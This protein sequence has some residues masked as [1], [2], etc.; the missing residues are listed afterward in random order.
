METLPERKLSQ[1]I[2]GVSVN[3]HLEK[4]NVSPK[5]K[6]FV[7]GILP[8]RL[9]QK[10]NISRPLLPQEEDMLLKASDGR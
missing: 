7:K 6:P 2:L 8:K 3:M 5:S 1:L 9:C 10:G 4:R